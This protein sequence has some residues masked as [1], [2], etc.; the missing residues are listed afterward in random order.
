MFTI[1]YGPV[2]AMPG[3][4][5]LHSF[6]APDVV[7]E[8]LQ[9]RLS[10]VVADHDQA[11]IGGVVPDAVWGIWSDDR[12]VGLLAAEH[13][14]HDIALQLTAERLDRAGLGDFWVADPEL[15]ALRDA[16]AKAM[17]ASAPEAGGTG[18]ASGAASTPA[19]R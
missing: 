6:S 11:L 13:V 19:T 17:E 7:E 4:V 2:P 1:A 15:E 16:S 12:V 18:S 10:I 9:C 14:R 5:H 8:R 3:R